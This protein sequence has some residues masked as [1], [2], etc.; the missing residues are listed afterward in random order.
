MTMNTGK[1]LEAILPKER[2]KCRLIDLVAYASDAGFYYLRPKAV[3]QPVSEEEIIALL[4]FSHQH[5]IPITFRT[6]G[7][8]LSGQSI[9]DGILVDLSQYWNQLIIEEDGNLVRVQPGI[10]G[11]MVNNYLKKHKRKIGPDPSSIDAAMMGG[12]LS[13][14]SSGMCCGVSLNSYHTT[15]HIRFILPSG[16]SFSTENKV[17]YS[18]FEQECPDVYSSILNLRQQIAD[19]PTLLGRIRTKYLSKNTV[20]YSLNA[21]IDYSHP[22]DIFS[23]LLIGAE[24]T[25]GFI[26]EA[27]MET[28]ADYPYKSSAFIYFENIYSACQAIEPLR[29]T[30]AEAV[31]LMDRASLRSIENVKGVPAIL[32]TLPDQAAALLVEY[33][34]NSVDELQAKIESLKPYSAKFVLLEP[35]SFTSD[36]GIQAFYWKLRK[37]MFPA[38][39]AVRAS[40]TTVVLED[41]AVP[42][43]QLGDA[44]LDLHV[45]FAKYK[46]DN[47]IIFGHAKDGNI[48]FVVT[49]SFNSANEVDRYDRFLREVVALVV[50]KY[51]GALKAEHGTG[52]NMA[53]FV[54]TEWG[55]EAYQIMKSLKKVI[56]PENLLNPGVIINEHKNAHLQDLKSLPVVE[57]EVDKCIECG[58]CEHKCPSRNVTLTPRQRIVVRRELALLE[59]D[60]KFELHAELVKQYQ[61]DG[62][63][64][65][66]VDG[67]CATSCPVDINT[68]DLVKRLRRESHSPFS[69]KVALFVSKNFYLVTLLVNFA[70]EAGTL[71]NSVF[72]KNAMIKLTK[73]FKKLIPEFP[74]WSNQLITSG[75]ISGKYVKEINLETKTGPAVV[76]FPTCISR[77]MGGAPNKKSIPDSFL[78]VSEKSG[79]QVIIPAG[80]EA[81]CCGQLFSS[82]GYNMAYA[83][84][85]NETIDKLW[86]V[87]K[88]GM[89]PI[90]LDVSS[91]SQTLQQCRPVL[92]D[93]NKQRFDRLSI[94]DSIDYLHDYVIP[95]CGPVKTKGT[96]VLHPVCSLQ[97]MGLEHKFVSVAS[98]F[99]EKAE[100]PIHSGCCGMAGDRGFIF[101]ELTASATAYEAN[102]VN[103]NSYE[104][105]YSSGKTCEISMSEAVGNNY[106]SILYLADE[107]LKGKPHD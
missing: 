76:Y 79:I 68:G 30:G 46:Y 26:A 71:V 48:H 98:H 47:A 8:S 103:K 33:Q 87:T 56:D 28:V 66:A 83:D 82:K 63:D 80:I 27:V 44:I 99:S 23:H 90:I 53:P 72:G 14:N 35:I 25:L 52:R 24:G 18:R 75:A 15:R 32:K 50:N 57:Q 78:S 34:S 54:E 77:V 85:C 88:E 81:L 42:V 1:L 5:K 6:G 107:C 51:D 7:T 36:P 39:G 29:M 96:V 41:I 67:L 64:T 9:T 97:K 73:V 65:C 70:L 13:N 31:E 12:I 60:G 49:Q 100:V 105:Y 43:A 16:K 91:C 38:V 102:E 92:N 104:G 19:N 89:L 95:A 3:V 45:L 59:A 61:Y 69:N 58:Y 4:A 106:E 22:L 93:L 2:I 101:P 86:T 40:G 55:T 20:G 74:L 62:L 10:T 11:S 17:D 37:G 94:L 21:F 84:K